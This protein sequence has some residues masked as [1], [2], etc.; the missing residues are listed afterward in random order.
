M[1]SSLRQARMPAKKDGGGVVLL[2][3]EGNQ[4]ATF[5]EQAKY[6]L[7]RGNAALAKIYLDKAVKVDPE[8]L[9]VLIERG[10]CLVKMGQPRKALLVMR[11]MGFSWLP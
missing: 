3:D 6:E 9:L 1:K 5:M 4:L 11:E 2:D 10:K 7:H 8:E